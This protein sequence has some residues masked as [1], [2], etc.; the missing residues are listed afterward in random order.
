MLTI[1]ESPTVKNSSGSG[2]ERKS[3]MRENPDDILMRDI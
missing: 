2:V 1:N 3:H